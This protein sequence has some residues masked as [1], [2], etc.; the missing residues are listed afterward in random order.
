MIWLM[1]GVAA[2]MA[3][4]SI[5]GLYAVFSTSH[6]DRA[7][8]IVSIE[9]LVVFGLAFWLWTISAR[10]VTLLTSDQISCRY[11]FSLRRLQREDIAGYRVFPK[12]YQYE[13]KI[14]SKTPGCRPLTSFPYNADAYFFQWFSSLPNLG[15][16]SLPPT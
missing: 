7:T 9:C 8:V 6:N 16:H 11:Y 15:G 2:F 10:I 5:C 1:K 13:I 14:Y 12:R 3:L 4:L